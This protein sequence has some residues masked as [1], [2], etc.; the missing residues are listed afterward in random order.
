[1]NKRLLEFDVI[2]AA[3]A[4]AVIAIHVTASYMDFTLAYLW[5][6]SVRFAVP[7]F[8][9]LSGFLLYYTDRDA[10]N[11]PVRAFYKKRLDRIL[12]PY[13]VWT[14]LYSLL[15]AYFLRLNNPLLFLSTLGKDL[16]WGTGYYH[17]WFL[18]I[19]LQFYILYPLLRRWM[20]KCPR[21]I[22]VGSLTISLAAQSLIYLYLLHIIALP[23]Q[24]SMF[25]ISAFPVWLFYF[26]FGMYMASA[27]RG[28]FLTS[29]CRTLS[30]SGFIWLCSLGLMLLDSRLTVQGSIVRPSVMLYAISSYFFFYALALRLS[31][32]EK[33]WLNWLSAQSFLI[34]LMHPLLLTILVYASIKIGHPG[35]WAGNRGLLGLYFFTT[36]STIMM[37]YVVSLSPLASLLGGIKKKLYLVK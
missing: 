8:I 34:Y 1:M 28:R 12:W 11:L 13:F 5:N 6:H 4:L 20:E 30:S 16:L 35:L 9:V 2:R 21:A 24:Y 27:T 26:V 25:Y 19:I 17:L 18:P 14:L 7:L 33:P 31:Q 32:K 22:L 23:G 15:N 37:T 29:P 36:V 10:L 3:A